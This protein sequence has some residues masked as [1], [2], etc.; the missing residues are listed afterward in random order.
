MASRD[1]F[2]TSHVESRR[3]RPAKAP[4]SR[5][6]IVAEALRQITSADG[7]GMSLR[8]IATA[9]DTGPASLYAY[10]DDMS[11]L[12][13]LVLDRALEDVTT[14]STGDSWRERLE[15]LLRSYAGVMAASPGIAQLAFQTTAMGPNALRIVE[16]I[17]ALLAEAGVGPASAAWA[18]HLLTVTATAI[19]VEN[20]DGADPADPDGPV[21]QALN[22]ASASDYPRLQA[23]REHMLS[24][25]GEQRFA[26][27]M[28]ILVRGIL[29]SSA[30]SG[31]GSEPPPV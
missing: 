12:Q 17:L 24:G 7:A 28:D 26:W 8:R 10:V 19:A 23:A 27:M 30:A 31:R 21:T 11:H 3:N 25:T 29:S 4:L 15:T 14:D 9:L 13:A 16:T 20:S 22:R 6:A 5:D 18:V 2:R 1:P